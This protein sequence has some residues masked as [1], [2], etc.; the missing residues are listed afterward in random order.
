MSRLR[1]ANKK[2]P[3]SAVNLLKLL[4]LLGHLKSTALS[5]QY[6]NKKGDNGFDVSH[7][8]I[9]NTTTRIIC[10]ACLALYIT[11]PASIIGFSEFFRSVQEH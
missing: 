3:D 11:Q 4:F 9:K 1:K 10:Q 7:N 5:E 6:E 8:F 2:P